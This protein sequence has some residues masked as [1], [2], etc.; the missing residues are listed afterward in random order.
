MG[1]VDSL[2]RFIRDPDVDPTETNRRNPSN[3]P[4]QFLSN[5]IRQEQDDL[6]KQIRFPVTRKRRFSSC[7]FVF[8]AVEEAAARFAETFI[9]EITTMTANLDNE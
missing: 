6:V 1:Y 9:N 8:Q 7:I 4:I 3:N 5:L 2:G